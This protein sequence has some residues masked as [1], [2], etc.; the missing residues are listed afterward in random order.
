MIA[1]NVSGRSAHPSAEVGGVLVVDDDER[2]RSR[3][4]SALQRHGCTVYLAAGG[5]EAVDI[6]GRH[7]KAIGLVLLDVQMPRQDGPQTLAAL[8]G[9]N[10]QVFCCFMASRADTHTPEELLHLGAARV[11]HKPLGE[12]EL[13]SLYRTRAGSDDRGPRDPG[14]GVLGGDRDSRGLREWLAAFDRAAD[15]LL[16][17]ESAYLLNPEDYRMGAEVCP[18]HGVCCARVTFGA[19][20]DHFPWKTTNPHALAHALLEMML[21]CGRH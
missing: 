19:L 20:R 13:R 3:L 17:H 5:R 18:D 1:G 2:V 15:G 7:L 14:L 16:A 11:F 9:M 8:K 21:P 6:Y 12:T 10:P 4:G